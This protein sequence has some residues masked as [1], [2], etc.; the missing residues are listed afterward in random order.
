VIVAPVLLFLEL[1]LAAQCQ[2]S[3]LQLD[4]DLVLL[5]AGQLRGEEQPI[6]V[7]GDIHGRQPRAEVHFLVAA[8][9]HAR[10][11]PVEAVGKAS[12]LAIRIP[13]NKVNHRDTS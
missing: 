3:A 1:A 7:F 12:K 13:G 11:R 4:L 2:N 8:S 9:G 10:K 6:L 5:K